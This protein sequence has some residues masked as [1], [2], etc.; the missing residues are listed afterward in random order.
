MDGKE[1]R[2]T[3][4]DALAAL[5]PLHI[6]ELSRLDDQERQAQAQEDA[7]QIAERADTLFRS[8][9]WRPKPGGGALNSIARGIANLA[10]QAG[11]VTAVG[12]HACVQA[13]EDCPAGNVDAAKPLRA[14]GFVRIIDE[15]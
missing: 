15:Q 8:G 2:Q 9:K 7:R 6:A 14:W 3:I 13:H 12:I 11:G 10:Y 4:Q 5:T 1:Q